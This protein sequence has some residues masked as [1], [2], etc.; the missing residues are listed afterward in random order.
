MKRLVVYLATLTML[1]FAVP[2]DT[3]GKDGKGTRELMRQKLKYA[4]QVLEGIAVKDFDMIEKN[5][6]KLVLVCK[7]SEWKVLQTPQYDAFS[8]EFRRNVEGLIDAAKDKNIDGA[9]LAY[10]ELTLTC[11]KCHKHVRETRM[12]FRDKSRPNP[13]KDIDFAQVRRGR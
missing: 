6:D 7:E 4:Q 12:G 8:N 5:G 9:A 10:V 13:G 1:A 3:V 2:G 11:V